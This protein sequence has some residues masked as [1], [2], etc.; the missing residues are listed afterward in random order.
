MKPNIFIGSSSEALPI[1]EEIATELERQFTVSLWKNDL[2]QIG[3]NTLEELLRFIQCY[4]F[5]ILVLTAD[6][7]TK[8]RGVE[9]A[10]PRDNVIFELGLFMG[11]LGRR[12]SFPVVV[13]T[14]D[15]TPKIPT[16]LLGNTGVYLSY[17]PPIGTALGKALDP[18]VT[19]I[20]QRAKESFLHLLPSTAL[21]IGYFRNFVLPVCQELTRRRS[22]EIGTM[23]VDISQDNFD[24]TIVLPKT[25]SD[26]STQG[27]S[28]FV[29]SSGAKDFQ[30]NCGPR[31]YPFYVRS[32][33]RDGRAVFYDYPTTL[34]ASQKAI[35]LALHRSS[36]GVSDEQ[37]TLEA[38][39]I[40]NFRRTIEILLEE[41]DAAEFRDNVKFV[42]AP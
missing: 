12:R 11:A 33:L 35:Q 16:D 21:A 18:L 42:V 13:K 1:A 30:L 15:G 6:D 23:E 31:S 26:A 10:S 24:F 41:P 32:E 20:N 4:D 5:A 19:A 9:S 39:E 40:A 27:A 38:K 34:N 37:R 3:E 29:K 7:F 8:S 28:K 14:P 2:F 22:V 25:L 17:P 36:L